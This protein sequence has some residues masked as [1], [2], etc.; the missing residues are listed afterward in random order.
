MESEA[1]EMGKGLASLRNGHK[2]HVVHKERG[3]GWG[4]RWDRRG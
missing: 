3:G 2:A 1:P 4:G